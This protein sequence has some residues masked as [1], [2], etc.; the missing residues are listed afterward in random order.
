MSYSILYKKQFIKIQDKYLVLMEVGD[1]NVYDMNNK[2]CRDWSVFPYFSRKYDN[3][4]ILTSEADI[5]SEIEGMRTEM[6]ERYS[7]EAENVDKKFS[8]Y[9]AIRLY[10]KTYCTFN[11]Y[12]NYFVNGMKEAI[13]F[14]EA[15]NNKFGI[16]LNFKDKSQWMNQ[17]ESVYPKTEQEF[18]D[19][20]KHIQKLISEK[21]DPSKFFM[22]TNISGGNNIDYYLLRKKD[23][24]KKARTPKT[25][26]Y[27]NYFV[28]GLRRDDQTEDSVSNFFYKSTRRGLSYTSSKQFAKR[29]RNEKAAEKFIQSKKALYK[30]LRFSIHN[31]K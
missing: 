16:S 23:M 21:E 15:V 10:G 28:V 14:E 4:N 19:G 27:E 3:N 30:D 17:T 11:E 18:L 6:L 31:V 8:W 2:R 12:K 29:Y 22:F 9:T 13:S 24:N 25:M 20:I 1:N 7:S 5:L 26:I